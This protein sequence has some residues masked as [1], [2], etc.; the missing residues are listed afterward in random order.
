MANKGDIKMYQYYSNVHGREY[1]MITGDNDE[2]RYEC[3][4]DL[5]SFNK[6]KRNLKLFTDI[7]AFENWQ[8]SESFED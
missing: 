7:E 2:E 6:Y 3:I 4:K 5:A 1:L 8:E